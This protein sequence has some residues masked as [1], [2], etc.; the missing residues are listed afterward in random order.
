MSSLSVVF[1]AP[2]YVKGKCGILA[3]S[4]GFEAG[5]IYTQW[6]AGIKAQSCPCFVE[7]IIR[8]S[9]IPFGDVFPFSNHHSPL[10]F[11]KN[12]DSQPA[13]NRHCECA[14]GFTTGVQPSLPMNFLRITTKKKFLIEAV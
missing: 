2:W 4:W 6:S 7:P 5:L 1:L 9:F 10:D 8:E 13:Y 3:G 11:F 12:L 14:F